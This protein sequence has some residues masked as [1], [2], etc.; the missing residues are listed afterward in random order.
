MGE[1]QPDAAGEQEEGD[2]G[3]GAERSTSGHAA[4]VQGTSG[5]PGYGSTGADHEGIVR[6]DDAPGHKGRGRHVPGRQA[7]MTSILR[8][9]SAAARGRRSVSRPSFRLAVMPSASTAVCSV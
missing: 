9:R 7:S 4:T 1:P 5:V 2:E 6:R 8:G 3:A